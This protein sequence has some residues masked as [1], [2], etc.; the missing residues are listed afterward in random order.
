[1]AEDN[2]QNEIIRIKKKRNNFVMMD[3]GFL[4]DDRLSFKS[5]GILAYLLSKPDNWKVIVRDLVNHAKDGKKAVYSGLQELKECGYYRKIPVRDET[6][7]R[8]KYWESVVFECPGKQET[9]NEG[10]DDCSLLTQKGEIDGTPEKSASSLFP[11]FVEIQNVQ[12]QN[13]DIQNGEHNN[14]Y[15]NKN[16]HNHIDSESKSRST[17][18]ET[19]TNDMDM[20]ANVETTSKDESEKP[21]TTPIND[22]QAKKRAPALT[23]IFPTYQQAEAKEKNNEHKYITYQ[24]MIQE[25]TNYNYFPSDDL[26]LVDNLIQ[27]MVDVILTEKPDTVKIGKELKP[28]QVV[29]SVYLKLKHDHIVHAISQYRNQ[30]HQI[31]YKTAYLRTLLYTVYQEIDAHYTNQVRADGLVW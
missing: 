31:K 18:D 26:A 9:S 23:P 11:P 22:P 2:R 19:L 6:G 17:S 10:Q 14:N 21:Q 20:T 5:K 13:V 7:Q 4:E 12:I 25:N 1:M 15:T 29:K 30:H 28:R 27:I 16:Y 8:I 3:K 24:N